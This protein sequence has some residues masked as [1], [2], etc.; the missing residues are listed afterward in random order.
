MVEVGLETTDVAERKPAVDIQFT[1]QSVLALLLLIAVAPVMVATAVLIFIED[2]GPVFF[3]QKRVGRGGRLFPCVK[4]RSMQPNAEADLAALLQ[5]SPDARREW[6]E[7][8]KLQ[9]DPRVTR[10]GSILR[11]YSLD[12]LPQL[13]NVAVGHM[14]F[15][16][17]RPIVPSETVRYGRRIAAYCAVKPGLTGLW[18]ISGRSNVRYRRRIAIDVIYARNKSAALDLK[19][20]LATAPAVLFSRGSY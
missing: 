10:I 11:R 1:V 19:I 14:E 4:F 9:V 16:G 3:V 13:M 20:V 8:Q 18:Q 12:E 6:A 17:P 7:T 15:V 5:T 2:G